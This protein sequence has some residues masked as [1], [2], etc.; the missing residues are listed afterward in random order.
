MMFGATLFVVVAVLLY[1]HF[2]RSFLI[3][4]T[5]R[6]YRSRGGEV[7]KIISKSKLGRMV[8]YIDGH[9]RKY[10]GNGERVDDV[11]IWNS[12]RLYEPI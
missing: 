6:S 1:M 10:Y 4:K 3:L 7:V 2:F 5:G 12:G 9:G 8:F 11:G